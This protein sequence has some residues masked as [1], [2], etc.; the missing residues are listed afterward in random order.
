MMTPAPDQTPNGGSRPGLARALGLRDATML[1]ISSVIGVGIFLTP[2]EVARAVPHPSLMLLA[3]MIGL[4]ISLAGALAN[5][6]LA[7]MFPRAGGDYIYL[8]E[9]YH[10]M[11]GFVAGVIAFVAIFAGTIATLSIGLAG[12]IGARFDFPPSLTTALGVLIV[13][14]VS[15]WSAQGVRASAFISNWTTYLKLSVMALVCLLGPILGSGSAENLLPSASGASAPWEG[16]VLAMPAVLFSYLGWNVSIYV[17][18]EVVNPGKTIPRSILVG[19]FVC[20][21]TYLAMTC[22]YLYAA[23]PDVLAATKMPIDLVG[24]ALFGKWGGL[25]V[26]VLVTMSMLGCLNANVL[27]GPRILYA[28]AQDGLFF[29]SAKAVDAR[30]QV[31]TNAIWVQAAIASGL[32]VLLGAFPNVLLHT[33]FAILLATIADVGALYVLRVRRPGAERPYRAAGYPAL[34]V[35]YALTNAAIAVTMLVHYPR[36]CG[37]VLLE[38]GLAIPLYF[39]FV[40]WRGIT[41]PATPGG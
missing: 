12:A 22:A 16:L 27:P 32:V 24:T 1:V 25:L 15:A 40:R 28:M 2:G 34:P 19:L 17:A 29:R 31:P 10:P 35:L 39:A 20:G 14:L 37:L 7:T 11:A 33:T 26:F 5:A 23:P 18:G 13:F 3:W 9:A 8:R 6:E 38:I 41:P 36:E 4:L 21:I 30:T